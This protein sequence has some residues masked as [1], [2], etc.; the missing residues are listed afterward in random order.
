MEYFWT[1]NSTHS[2]SSIPPWIKKLSVG[3]PNCLQTA[4]ITSNN[5]WLNNSFLLTLISKFWRSFQIKNPF[6][7]LL[8]YSHI[9]LLLHKSLVTKYFTDLTRAICC[10]HNFYTDY[11]FWQGFW[12]KFLLKLV[13][14]HP[15]KIGR[16]GD[17]W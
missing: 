16:G 5:V 8:C 3:L 12:D 11:H 15:T 2:V 6:P 1:L 17:S 14:I 4:M 9:F 7:T 10:F 13:S